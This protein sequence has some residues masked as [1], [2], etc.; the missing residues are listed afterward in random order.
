MI[1]IRLD[2]PSVPVGGE[3]A[4]EVAWTA[5]K[6]CTPRKIAVSLG[7]RTEGRGDADSDVVASGEHDCGPAFA[8]DVVRLPFRGRVP[9]NAV[10]S[11]AGSLIRLVWNVSV[12]VDLPW[13]FDEK[14]AA[15]FEVYAP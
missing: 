10:P 4:G 5:E 2:S 12:R 15:E 14:A 9:E 8:G 7:W 13:A 3:V 6:D 11:F 1:E